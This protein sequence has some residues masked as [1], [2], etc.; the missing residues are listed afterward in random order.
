LVPSSGIEPESHP[1]QGRA[2][3]N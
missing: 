1:L 3:T 2:M